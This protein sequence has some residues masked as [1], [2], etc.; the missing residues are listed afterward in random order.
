ARCDC[1]TITQSTLSRRVARSDADHYARQLE[2]EQAAVA[3]VPEIEA[4]E[5]RQVFQGYGLTAKESGPIVEALRKRPAP[6]VDFMMRFELGLEEP[7]PKRALTSALTIAGAYMG[8]GFIPLAPYMFSASAPAA[9]PFSVAV[10][11]SAL[12]IFGFV[13]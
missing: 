8:G 1:R 10:T 13:K 6:W 3:G 5:V 12:L 7:D 2:R 9:L 11:L 4:Q